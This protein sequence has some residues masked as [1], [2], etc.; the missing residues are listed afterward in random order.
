M[1]Y[2]DPSDPLLLQV[3]PRRSER[4]EAPG[5]STDPVGDLA[6]QQPAGLLRKYRGRALLVA[7]GACA[8]HC[9][10]C[11]RR[12]FPYHDIPHAPRD[13]RPA[14]AEIAA[15]E[16]LSEVLVSGGDP[17]MLKDHHLA[18]MTTALAAIPHL[19]RLRF[20]TRLPIMIPH[21]VTDA[22]LGVLCDRRLRSY[23][24][25]HVNHP[26]EIDE[27]VAVA[28]VRLREAG[29][30]LLNQ[31]VL[32]RGVNDNA[33][34]LAD[35]CE[36][37]VELGV[38]PYYLHQLDRVSGAAHFETPIERG[39]EIIRRLRGRLPGYAVPRYVQEIAG[40]PNKTVLA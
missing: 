25:V 17:W 7:T 28:L 37:L 16:S 21:R 5:F 31:S 8:V 33:D 26:A 22:L 10:Y 38:I 40:Q 19:K 11:F 3:L 34:I 15:D 36:R 12:H 29:V 24:V 2:G 30:V 13:W 27:A 20:H 23:V 39:I 6:A 9:R 35:L 14:L 32:L 4:A 18:E 1:Q